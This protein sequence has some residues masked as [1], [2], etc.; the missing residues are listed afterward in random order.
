MEQIRNII[1]DWGGV[2]TNI[3][4]EAT[5][6]AFK[7]FGIDNFEEYYCQTYQSELFILHETGQ[8]SPEEF[9][10]ELKK[11][12]PVPITDEELDTAWMAMLMET[13]PENIGLLKIAKKKYRTFLLSNTNAIHVAQYGKILKEKFG[14]EN[15]MSDVF[16]KVY[17]S[18]EIGMKKPDTAIFKFLLEENRLTPDETLFVDD[19][20]QNIDAANSLGLKTILLANG[21]TL[22][23]SMSLSRFFMNSNR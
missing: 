18:H 4:F 5:I 13:P 2:I 14:L 11:E 22:G 23:N 7:K 9:R 8:I 10:T 15:G 6:N 1:F 20:I 3:D 12:I 17:Y 19:S 21:Q 16:E